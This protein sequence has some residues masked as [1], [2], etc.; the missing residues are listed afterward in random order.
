MDNE[1]TERLQAEVD[2]SRDLLRSAGISG[3]GALSEGVQRLTEQHASRPLRLEL[4]LSH[5]E[6]LSIEARL[7]ANSARLRTDE[8]FRALLPLRLEVMR[9]VVTM[10]SGAKNLEGVDMVDAIKTVEGQLSQWLRQ[11]REAMHHE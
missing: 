7:R 8:D 6:I 10:L 9:L 1:R 5:D 4:E 3:F 2:R 11:I